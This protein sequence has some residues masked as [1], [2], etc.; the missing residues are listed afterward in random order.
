MDTPP[1]PPRYPELSEFRRKRQLMYFRR[2]MVMLIGFLAFLVIG[3]LTGWYWL[4]IVALLFPVLLRWSGYL[5][6]NNRD[7]GS[8]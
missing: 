2:N 4:Y 8:L 7:G 5:P 1:E 6:E 3:T